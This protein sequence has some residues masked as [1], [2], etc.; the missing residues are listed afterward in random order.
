MDVPSRRDVI[1]GSVAGVIA[2][3]APYGAVAAPAASWRAY[4]RR[5][6]AGLVRTSRSGRYKFHSLD[7]SPLREIGERWPQR[8]GDQHR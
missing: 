5:L 7:T 4:D 3:C 6:Q 1:I 2:G 8:A